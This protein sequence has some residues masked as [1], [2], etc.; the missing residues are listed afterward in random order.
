[1]MALDWQDK[2]DNTQYSER[3]FNSNMS[4]VAISTDTPAM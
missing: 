4:F 2:T 1:M 3:A